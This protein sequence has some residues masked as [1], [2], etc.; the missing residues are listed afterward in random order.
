L[1]LRENVVIYGVTEE[2]YLKAVSVSEAHQIGV[3]E[4]LAYVLMEKAEICKIYLFDKDF[5]AFK[6]ISRIIE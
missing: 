4:A 5:D 2:D 6:D 1:L 3:N